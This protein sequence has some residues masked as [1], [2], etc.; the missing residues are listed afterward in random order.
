MD[1][2]KKI[3]KRV[4]AGTLATASILPVTKAEE[5]V[6]IPNSENIVIEETEKNDKTE[7]KS[8]FEANK[9]NLGIGA[10]AAAVATFVGVGLCK[11]FSGSEEKSS[12]EDQIKQQ[13]P[14][15]NKNEEKPSQAEQPKQKE[16]PSQA[17][18][19]KQQ[20]SDVNEQKEKPS[21]AEQPKQKEELSQAE[22]PEQ[23][24]EP[25][26]VEQPKQKEEPS[27]AEQPKQQNFDTNRRKKFDS[28]NTTEAGC[29]PALEDKGYLKEVVG[30][31]YGMKNV[32][33]ALRQRRN[34]NQ[35]SNDI[36]LQYLTFLLDT[37]DSKTV[38]SRETLSTCLRGIVRGDLDFSRLNENIKSL[39]N[40]INGIVG[41]CYFNF[42]EGIKK[43]QKVDIQSIYHK[44]A[45]TGC[46]L[47]KVESFAL[48]FPS[49]QGYSLYERGK[50]IF[51]NFLEID[52]AGSGNKYELCS[53]SYYDLDR[54]QEIAEPN[55]CVLL[56]HDD[57]NW[58]RHGQEH[59][60]QVDKK[61]VINKAAMSGHGFTYSKK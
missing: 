56:K 58:Y 41:G 55:L 33:E 38:Y 31:A 5:N 2:N 42:F 32:K 10:V 8:W 24:E 61:Y 53:V 47:A 50:K 54:D 19:P 57:G 7:S 35:M 59:V 26:Q 4:L 21:Q 44:G 51:E 40:R 28:K 34:S 18:Q 16:E 11:L 60:D 9:K 1:L 37:I 25:S 3:L 22:Q 52:D 36:Q 30:S 46:S 13:N 15:A 27:R 45:F 39:W 49:G 17:E 48:W 23:K 6:N 14:D 20:N 43:G 12:Q 29:L